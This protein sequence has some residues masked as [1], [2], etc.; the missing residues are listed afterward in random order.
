[1][2]YVHVFADEA[3]NFD[4]TGGKGASRYFILTTVTLGDCGIGNNLLALRRQLVLEGYN[5]SAE[6]HATEERQVLRD[7]IFALIEREGPEGM[8]IDASIFNKSKVAP[9]LQE[10]ELSFYQTAWYLHLKFVAPQIAT[11]GDELL[12]IAAALGTKSKR[13]AFHLAVQNVVSQVAENS[14]YRTA[15][16][17]ASADP[18][19]Q[20]AD[21][22]CWAIQRKWEQNDDRS[23]IYIKDKIRTEYL[24]FGQKEHKK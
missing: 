15:F 23:H 6:V 13:A 20:I 16:W 3:G 1:M 18:C 21:Y 9:H 5:T 2:S 11:S 8:R 22:C 10:N 7:R 4:F 12:V 17:P 24:F 19:L 14:K